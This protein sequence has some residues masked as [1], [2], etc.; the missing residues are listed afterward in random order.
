MSK[1]VIIDKKLGDYMVIVDI[2]RPEENFRSLVESQR[3]GNVV[4]E[5]CDNYA[6]AL[7]AVFKRIDVGYINEENVNDYKTVHG[8]DLSDTGLK[9]YY[10][11]EDKKDSCHGSGYLDDPMEYYEEVMNAFEELKNSK[12]SELTPKALGVIEEMKK[13]AEALGNGKNAI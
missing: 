9:S 3:V 12:L 8:L 2:E 6:P 13:Y 1:Y 7:D 11:Y 5:I 10:L 4:Y